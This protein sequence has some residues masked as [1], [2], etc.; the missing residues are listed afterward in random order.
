M[1]YDEKVTFKELMDAHLVPI[2]E[3]LEQNSA[4]FKETREDMKEVKQILTEVQLQTTR[5]NGR[6]SKLDE[7]S[8]GAKKVIENNTTAVADLKWWRGAVIWGA[9]I[10]VTFVCI[11]YPVLKYIVQR[12]IEET[13][14]ASL[15]QFNIVVK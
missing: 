2:H 8:E 13:V 1:P 11:S 4:L 3:R 5:T 15:A 14:Q 6:V 9:G 12:Q 7:W 10:L